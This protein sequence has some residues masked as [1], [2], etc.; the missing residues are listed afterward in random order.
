MAY[1]EMTK[2]EVNSVSGKK[3]KK[4]TSIKF[5]YLQEQQ[6]QPDNMIEAPTINSSTVVSLVKYYQ[7][8]KVI[9]QS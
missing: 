7:F 8:D 5:Y 1:S 3:D 6:E 2:N 9:H 4:G